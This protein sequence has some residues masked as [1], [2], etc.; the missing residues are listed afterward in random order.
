[1]QEVWKIF[2]KVA[3]YGSAEGYAVLLPKFESL[4]PSYTLKDTK[5]KKEEVEK[6]H[7]FLDQTLKKLQK[8]SS[9]INTSIK[10]LVDIQI[11]FLKDPIFLEEVEKNIRTGKNLVQSIFL[12]SQM[13]NQ[14]FFEKSNSLIK[15]RWVDI[16]DAINQLLE[17]TLGYSYTDLCIQKIN[18][19]K[20][21][22]NRYILVANNISPLL[23]LRIPKPNGVLL[24][25]GDFSG[26]LI[27]LAANQ[28]IPI[29]I[30]CYP[31]EDFKKIFDEFYIKI[32]TKKGY[33]EISNKGKLQKEIDFKTKKAILNFKITDLLSISL[34]AD[35]VEIIKKHKKNY[36]LSL[37]LFRT[38]FMYLQQ[39]ELIHNLEKSINKYL[40]I[41]RLLN[42]GEILTLRLIDVDEDKHSIFFYT[43]EQNIG[44]RGIEYYKSETEILINQLK[45][46]FMAFRKIQNPNWKLK[47]LI[48]MITNYEDWIFIKKIVIQEMEILNDY[49]KN[50]I[51]LGIMLEV[52]SIFYYVNKLEG[53]D[54]Y[55]IGTNDLLAF[56][57]G[58]KRNLI[59]EE[60]YFDASF[61]KML[62]TFLHPLQGEISLCGTLAARKEFLKLLYFCGIRNFSVPYGI[63]SEIYDYCNN[64]TFKENDFS[65]FFELL[66]ILDPLEFK[67]R[68]LEFS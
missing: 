24:L 62:Y 20:K 34:N 17:E 38:E 56:F 64:L 54:F 57:F 25:E 39:P 55:S 22:Y 12:S 63:Y 46:I 10:E 7:Q 42:K 45:S 28:G 13:I 6:F 4:I 44:K 67:K 31:E 5:K 33:A 23:Y 43:S 51:Q 41:F 59:K 68:L 53:V 3:S 26:H 65:I 61:Y 52:P 27:L 40:K 29:L 48:P 9:Q 19:F 30:Q 36:K 8:I 50:Q 21:K 47:I 66:E 15:E 32:D 16:Q 60:D 14:M 35:D 58:K 37:G 1:M 2:G 49:H 11:Y 18:Q